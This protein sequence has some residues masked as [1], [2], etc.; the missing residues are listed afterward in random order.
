[1]TSIVS[2]IVRS[3]VSGITGSSGG[4]VELPP[5]VAQFIINGPFAADTDWGK[6]MGWT[7]AAGVATCAPEGAG[8]LSQTMEDGLRIGNSY[9]FSIDIVA[10]PSGGVVRIVVGAQTIYSL[11]TD[12]GTLSFTFISTTTSDAF[13][14]RLPNG[15]EELGMVIDNVSLVPTP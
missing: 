2:S 3:I 1:M 10:N 5:E 4:A 7:I 12:P 14:I 9:D 11:A 15:D 13:G 6:G 8:T